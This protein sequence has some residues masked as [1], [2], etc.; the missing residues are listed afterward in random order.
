M[1]LVIDGGMVMT[2]R[3]RAQSAADAAATATATE[4]SEGATAAAARLTGLKYADYNGFSNDGTSN[5]VTVN[6]PPLSGPHAGDSNFAEVLTTRIMPTYFIRVVFN[7]PGRANARAVAGLEVADASGAGLLVLNPQTPSALSVTGNA[8]VNVNG[9]GVVVNSSHSVAV[10]GTGNA[11]LN[12]TDIDIGGSYSLSG[13]AEING[14]ISTGVAPTPDPLDDLPAPDP[15]SLPLQSASPLSF[16]GSGSYTL[17]PG[18]Y[19]G[20]VSASGRVTITLLPGVYYMDEGGLSMSGRT[21]LS[22]P[23]VM[24][25]SERSISLTG[26]GAVTLTPPMSGTYRGMALFQDRNT[27]TPTITLTG[28][29]AFNVNGTIYA[30]QASITVTGNGGVNNLGS[31]IIGDRVTLTGNASININWDPNNVAQKAEVYLVE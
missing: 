2:E 13:N 11:E 18:R 21:S 3:R 28:N 4:L 26:S 29:G 19:V 22:G 15:A 9:A 12:A 8:S 14:S 1:G 5:T 27:T 17:L 20:G 16:S 30:P 6:I 25:Y 24:I 23:G 10:T 31:Q 7:G